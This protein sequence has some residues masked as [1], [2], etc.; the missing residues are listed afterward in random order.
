MGQRAE[1]EKIGGGGVKK[2][3]QY[4]VGALASLLSAEF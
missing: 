1:V 3:R 4:D 2:G